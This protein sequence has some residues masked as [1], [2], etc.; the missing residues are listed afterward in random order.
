MMKKATIALTTAGLLLLTPFSVFA[1][2]APVTYTDLQG[3]FARQAVEQLAASGYLNPEPNSTFAPN[4]EIPRN[5][6]NGWVKRVFGVSVGQWAPDQQSLPLTRA[7]AAVLIS[8]AYAATGGIAD[9]S[10]KTAFT[11]LTGATAVERAAINE[12][13]RRGVLK[14]NGYGKFLPHQALTR[15]EAAVILQKVIENAQQG[16]QSVPFTR[17]QD[18]DLPETAYTMVMENKSAAG[19]FSV[20]EGGYRYVMVSMGEQP[21]TGYAIGVVDVVETPTAF[22]VK[23]AESQPAPGLMQAQVITYPHEVI[24]LKDSKKPIFL[25][26]ATQ[27]GRMQL[28]KGAKAKLVRQIDLYGD[29]RLETVAAVGTVPTP[30]LPDMFQSG[31]LGVFNEQGQVEQRVA[32]TGDAVNGPVLLAAKDVDR[33]GRLDLVLD[34]DLRGNGG[35]GVH[36][37]NV[38]V[39]GTNRYFAALPQQDPDW[40]KELTTKYDAATKT[41]TIHSNLDNRNFKA[42]YI[43]KAS[44]DPIYA[45]QSYDRPSVDPHYELNADS[46]VLETKHWL[47][48]G[49]HV[50]G[51]AILS[52]KHEVKDGKL[53]VSS[54]RLDPVDT[55][56][57]VGE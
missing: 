38:F 55:D 22:V 28:E 43:G 24:R 31:Y 36:Q 46:N 8:K 11:D 5:V 35:R 37:M 17:L 53:V 18:A 48:V 27:E 13:N 21:T 4:K 34:S 52:A 33:D 9:T 39:Q 1:T 56:W 2:T 32:L 6:F 12:L 15:G 45:G 19:V 42:Q 54:Y 14:G 50:N 41:W 40:S 23:T 25:Q 51:I 57:K 7:E 47:S 3:H 16:G 44:Y 29:G 26:K 20:S 49:P 10:G 30:D